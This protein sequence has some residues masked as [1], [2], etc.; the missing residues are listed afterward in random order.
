MLVG[1]GTVSSGNVLGATTVVSSSGANLYMYVTV[2][3]SLATIRANS[4]AEALAN[5]VNIASNSGVVLVNE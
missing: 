2:S 3:G 5:A 4:P 1:S